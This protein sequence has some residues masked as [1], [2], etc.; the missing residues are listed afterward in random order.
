[1]CAYF[2]GK[3]VERACIEGKIIQI[4]NDSTSF[5]GLVR[6]SLA[7]PNFLE[8]SLVTKEEKG[9]K[10]RYGTVNFERRKYPRFHVDLPIEYY[11]IDSSIG[12]TGKVFNI[13][14][15]G[16]LLH[17]PEQMD[18]GQYMKLKLFFPSGSELNTIEVLAEVVWVDMHL[19]KGWKDYRCGVNFIDV[20][21][22]DIIKLKNFLGTLPG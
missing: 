8:K 6:K 14:E 20:S 16:L 7:E 2:L 21:P 18:I 9:P 11:R 5:C 10:P 22:E 12:H 13:S 4:H 19:G 1:M 3:T 17:F 15:G